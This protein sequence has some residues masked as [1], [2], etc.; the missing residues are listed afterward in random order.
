MIMTRI[1]IDLDCLIATNEVVIRIPLENDR[2]IVF[3]FGQQTITTSVY[4]T[5]GIFQGDIERTYDECQKE[6]RMP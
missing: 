1:E 3:Q 5:D 4:G 2:V 6:A